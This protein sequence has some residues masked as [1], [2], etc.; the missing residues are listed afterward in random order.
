MWT[1]YVACVMK[2]HCNE[3]MQLL[4]TILSEW[5]TRPCSTG[6]RKCF[7]LSFWLITIFLIDD[8]ISLSSFLHEIQRKWNPEASTGWHFQCLYNYV[9]VQI[10]EKVSFTSVCS[11]ECLLCWFCRFWSSRNNVAYYIKVDMWKTLG[12]KLLNTNYLYILFVY[13]V[14]F[15]IPALP[16]FCKGCLMYYTLVYSFFSKIAWKPFDFW[17]CSIWCYSLFY[18]KRCC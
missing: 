14:I 6:T 5:L 8:I 10:G 2:V 12:G 16:F 13:F 4:K 3:K 7:Q 9:V 1:K 17:Y 18:A 11:K 15:F